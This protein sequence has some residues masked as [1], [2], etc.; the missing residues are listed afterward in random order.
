MPTWCEFGNWY[1][2]PPISSMWKPIGNITAA[3]QNSTT[4]IKSYIFYVKNS[5][6]K[7]N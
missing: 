7:G 5:F 1:G 2:C 3:K 4:K 6:L